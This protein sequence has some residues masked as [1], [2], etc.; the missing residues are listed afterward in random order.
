MRLFALFLIVPLIE[1]ALFITVG[2]W[3]TLW[4]TLGLVL[5]TGIAGTALMRWQGLKVLAELRGDM[6]Q[7]KNP[8]SPLAHGALILLAG[9]LLL[10][11]GFFTDTIGFLLMVPK[12]REAVIRFVGARVAVQT[13][14]SQQ[15]R[16]H[17]HGPTVID[18]EF[19]EVEENPAPKGPSGWTRH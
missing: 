3:L 7:L 13:F 17:S 12:L 11:P 14:G 6:G 5:L 19:F 1:I 16:S 2:G 4:P 15:T 9:L 8:L 18:G 10:T